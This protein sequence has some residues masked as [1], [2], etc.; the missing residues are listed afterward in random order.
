MRIN[1]Q[2]IFFSIC[3]LYAWN[4]IQSYLIDQTGMSILFVLVNTIIFFLQ[5]KPTSSRGIFWTVIFIT[6]FIASTIISYFFSF[7][8]INQP[9]LI[10]LKQLTST[11]YI[12]YPLN[13]VLMLK[14]KRTNIENILQSAYC[15]SIIVVLICLFFYFFKDPSNYVDTSFAGFNELKSTDYYFLYPVY[16]IQL[17]SFFWLLAPIKRELKSRKNLWMTV[18]GIVSFLFIL[19]ANKYRAAKAGYTLTILSILIFLNLRKGRKWILIPILLAI[20]LIL[21]LMKFGYFG[22]AFSEFY[23]GISGILDNSTSESID[24]SLNYRKI[25]ADTAFKYIRKSFL[26][27]IGTI[28][29]EWASISSPEFVNFFASDLGLI[30]HILRSGIVGT[31]IR[32][33]PLFYI[34]RFAINRFKSFTY[35]EAICFFMSLN[36]YLNLFY[37][38]SIKH[39]SFFYIIL[40]IYLSH[41]NYRHEKN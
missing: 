4:F 1:G 35:H 19:F 27:G 6:C 26:F 7:Y 17:L 34:L 25:Q 32:F 31:L 3:N 39:D 8:V 20:P 13:I 21:I 24:P 36:S 9:V 15:S 28:N 23:V 11:L 22:P 29:K 2:I 30:G 38:G 18:F 14:R 12:L 10:S 33:F 37:S 41:E 40:F 5:F 16:P